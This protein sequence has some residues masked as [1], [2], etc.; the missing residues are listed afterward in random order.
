MPQST[1]SWRHSNGCSVSECVRGRSTQC[2]T[3]RI[4]PRRTCG[5]ASS[6]TANT[7]PSL[8]PARR[9]A[10]GYAR[11]SRLGTTSDGASAELLSM[12]VGQIDLAS[13]T[14]RLEVGETKND[15]G[16]EVEM[17]PLVYALIQQCV[18]GKQA[19][20]FV[21]TRETGTAVRDFRGSWA[22]VC[23]AAG[24]GK[25]VCP[26]CQRLVQREVTG[27]WSCAQCSRAWTQKELDYTGLIFHDLR[28]TAVRNM[29]RRGIPERVA[30]M[31]SGH[32]TR[33][34]FDRYNIVSEADLRE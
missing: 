33:S 3:S 11:C 23:C 19:E 12:R 31:I 30:M 28:R 21:F 16:R 14:I 25:M 2:P 13:R 9:K 26:H 24:V 34:V 1:V 20:D 17:T 8:R 32:K 7:K 29:V 22:K 5:R 4:L 10:C 15:E 27:K 6:R 18:T